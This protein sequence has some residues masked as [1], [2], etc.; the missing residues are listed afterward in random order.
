MCLAVPG[1]VV[2]VEGSDPLLRQGKVEFGGIRKRVNLSLVPD[3]GVGDWVLV[4]VGVA[5]NQLDEHE[6]RRTLDYLREMGDLEELATDEPME[7]PR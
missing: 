1:R 7:P 4:H 5:L 6:A 2:S 3:A